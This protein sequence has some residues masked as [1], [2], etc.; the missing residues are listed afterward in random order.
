MTCILVQRH[1]DTSQEGVKNFHLC[2]CLQQFFYVFVNLDCNSLQH[3]IQHGSLFSAHSC[4]NC[5]LQR[6]G[7]SAHGVIS[8]LSDSH[9]VV[10]LS[11]PFSEWSRSC[12]RLLSLPCIC[13]MAQAILGSKSFGSVSLHGGFRCP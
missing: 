9:S 12:D 7:V 4:F 8:V 2:L 5:S 11:V 3:V 6:C 10:L 1:E 13:C